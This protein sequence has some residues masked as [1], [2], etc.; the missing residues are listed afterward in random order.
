M[1]TPKKIKEKMEGPLQKH[2]L[3]HKGFYNYL[4]D[5]NKIRGQ[6]RYDNIISDIREALKDEEG[7]SIY[8]TGHRYVQCT[9]NNEQ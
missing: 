2:L 9:M 7:Y 3:V 5:N 8:V 4:F 6:Q 1:E